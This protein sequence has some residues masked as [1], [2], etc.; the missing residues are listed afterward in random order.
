ME[1]P[2]AGVTV[3]DAGSATTQDLAD[4]DGYNARIVVAVGASNAV[5]YTLDGG[6]TWTAVTGP[7][8]TVNLTAVNLRNE[9]EWWIGDA[10]GDLWYTVDKGDHWYEMTGLKSTPTKVEVILWTDKPGVG[11]VA[12]DHA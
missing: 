4:V 5:V 1:D 2:A 6:A 7:A 10:N 8:P 11:F 9:D 12:T 3:L